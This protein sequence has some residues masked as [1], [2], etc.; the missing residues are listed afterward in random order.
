MTTSELIAGKTAA[1]GVAVVGVLAAALA[2]TPSIASQ[3]LEWGAFFTAIAAA[4][5]Y[6]SM[7]GQLRERQRAD[8]KRFKR[9]TRSMEYL[10]ACVTLIAE[11]QG[12]HL[13]HLQ[14]DFQSDED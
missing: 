6:G 5:G 2:D 8:E 4:V 11:K 10:E 12:I 7:R 3:P 9:V 13:S 1:L 14:A